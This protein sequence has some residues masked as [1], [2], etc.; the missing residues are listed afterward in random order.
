M[1]VLL[2]STMSEERRQN[3]YLAD[4]TQENKDR[5]RRNAD[6]RDPNAPETR[7]NWYASP[8]RNHKKSVHLL[9]T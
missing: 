9:K 2:V 7:D 6:I 5:Q 8:V 1:D 4:L 3:Q